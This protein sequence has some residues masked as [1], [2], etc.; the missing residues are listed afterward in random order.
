[1]NLS[2]EELRFPTTAPPP[3]PAR[4]R[5]PAAGA[6]PWAKAH[7]QMDRKKLDTGNHVLAGEVWNGERRGWSLYCGCGFFTPLQRSYGDALDLLEGHW[8]KTCPESHDA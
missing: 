8:L 2:S 3:E 1:M 6:P 4:Y 7:M 5:P